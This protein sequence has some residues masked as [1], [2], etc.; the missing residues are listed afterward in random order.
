MADL[1]QR[2][3]KWYSRIRSWNGYKQVEKY[4]PL[5]TTSKVEAR[6]RHQI[7][8][9]HEKDIKEGLEFNF[10]WLSDSS[11]TKISVKGLKYYIDEYLEKLQ[12]KNTGHID[13]LNS[14]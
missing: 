9:K 11:I 6:I 10:A 4:I 7:V 3:K 8:E 1:H 2:R 13:M 14:L 5:K 12:L